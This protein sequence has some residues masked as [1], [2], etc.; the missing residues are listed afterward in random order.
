MCGSLLLRDFKNL[1]LHRGMKRRTWYLF[2]NEP[3]SVWK[4]SNCRD[5]FWLLKCQK[6]LARCII[7][8]RPERL[9]SRFCKIFCFRSI[10]GNNNLQE[11]TYKSFPSRDTKEK[12]CYIHLGITFSSNCSGMVLVQLYWN[13]TCLSKMCLT[14]LTAYSVSASVNSTGAEDW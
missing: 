8:K 5:T 4:L 11:A 14:T 9:G 10:N 1:N 7:R 2:H 13:T 6:G 3:Q 12:C